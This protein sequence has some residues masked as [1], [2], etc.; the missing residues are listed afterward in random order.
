VDV[1]YVQE[2]LGHSSLDSTAI[3][4]HVSIRALKEVHDRTHPASRLGKSSTTTPSKMGS[5]PTD[6]TADA[7]LRTLAVEGDKDE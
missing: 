5:A 7:L 3:Y 6:V 1:R 4:T 2:M